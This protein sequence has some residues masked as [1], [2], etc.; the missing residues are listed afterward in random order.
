M[1]F[2]AVWLLTDGRAEGPGEIVANAMRGY[3]EAYGMD[4]LQVIGMAPWRKLVAS[5]S[6]FSDDYLVN[7]FQIT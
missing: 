3:A 7:A 1:H 5:H 2:S 4:K 6:L